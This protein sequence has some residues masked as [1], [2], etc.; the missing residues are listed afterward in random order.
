MASAEVVVVDMGAQ[1]DVGFVLLAIFSQQ[2]IP[3]PVLGHC[4]MAGMGEAPASCWVVFK[5]EDDSLNVNPS[6]VG[7]CGSD[8]FGN[9]VFPVFPV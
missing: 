4:C 9:D 6:M 8:S 5:I 7:D 2:H 1:D 3:Q